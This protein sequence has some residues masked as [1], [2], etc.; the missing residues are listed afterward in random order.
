VR[1]RRETG[2]TIGIRTPSV[3]IP[4]ARTACAW[5]PPQATQRPR[6][7]DIV[8][9]TGVFRADEI[10]VAL[11][12][13]DA[14][15]S[16]PGEDYS[17]I[18]AYSKTDEMAAFAFFGPT[19]CTLGTWDLYWIVVHPGFQGCGVGRELVERVER[20]MRSAGA[21]MCI[22]ETSSRDDYSTT[23][24][25]YLACGYQEVARIADFYD[26]GDDRVTYAKQFE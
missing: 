17:A 9:A 15:C 18:A 20:Q 26:V 8:A 6:I 13:F 24:R 22:I 23:R 3:P 2:T 5:K 16:A 25:F 4:E 14:Y 19:P 1:P 11:E 12:V 7:A 10:D 21:R